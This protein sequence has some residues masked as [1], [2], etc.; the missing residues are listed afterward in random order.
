MR[1]LPVE[2]VPG[3]PP[4]LL[5]LSIIRGSPVPVVELSQLIGVR[6]DAP[7]LRFVLLRLG[8]RRVALAVNEVIGLHQLHTN[9]LENLPPLLQNTNSELVTAVGVMDAQL[10][11]IL[12]VARVITDELWESLDRQGD[13]V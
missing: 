2:A 4:F 10:L 1:P 12:Q 3:M 13:D 7:N 6:T 9:V 8:E 11:F 5:G